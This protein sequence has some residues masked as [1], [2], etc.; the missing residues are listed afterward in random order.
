MKQLSSKMQ[1]KNPQWKWA[2]HC[3][4]NQAQTMMT[5]PELLQNKF[6]LWYYLER[7]VDKTEM[8]LRKGS[9]KLGKFLSKWNEETDTK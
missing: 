5:Q 6:S 4:G 7:G 1:W 2:P 8:L 9:E 3:S